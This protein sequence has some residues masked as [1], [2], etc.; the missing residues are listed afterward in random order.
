M[1][2]PCVARADATSP[3]RLSP[4]ESFAEDGTPTSAGG[5]VASVPAP[6]TVARS[7][8]WYVLRHPQFRAYFAGSLV[9]NLGTWLQNTAQMLLAYKMTHSAFAVGLIACAQFSGFLL[10][11]PWAGTLANRMGRK[12]VLIWAQILSAMVA[13]GLAA[14]IFKRHLTE[15][16]LVIGALGTG[17][18]LTFSLPVQTAMVAALVPEQET[19]AA[20]AMNSVSYNGGRT[21]APV[22]S[23]AVLATIGPGWAFALN[24]V[25]FL[26]FAWVIAAVYPRTE[27]PQTKPVHSWSGLRFAIRRPRIM[28]LLAMVAA[29]TI[30]DDPVLVLGPSLARHVLAVSSVWPAYFLS[31]LGMGTVLGGLLP[32]RPTNSRRAAYPL[33]ALAVSVMVFAIGFSVWI[34]FF[35]AV[36]AGVAGL[37]TGASAQALLLDQAGPRHATQVMGLWAVA[38]AGSKPVASLADGLLAN[39]VG[40][41]WTAMILALPAIGIALL[42]MYPK[43]RYYKSLLKSYIA[44][45]NLD[46]G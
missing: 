26:V 44:R 34:S 35:A 11:G 33:A 8:S 16:Y 45:Y 40:V 12:R 42:E 15:T 18:A 22:L 23:L 7:T 10:I 13:A 31:A 39:H 9:S 21:F 6:T 24:T 43:N 28:L 2:T 30:A 1:S 36:A 41:R 25:S 3:D 17:L 29:V 5:S 38:W 19:K 4:A 46:H 14:L 37:L 27:P 20:L 32:P